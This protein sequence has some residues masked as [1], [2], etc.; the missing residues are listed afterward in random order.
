MNTPIYQNDFFTN[1]FHM[2]RPI[3]YA[4]A[5]LIFVFLSVVCSTVG[6]EDP[7][8]PLYSFVPVNYKH[9]TFDDIKSNPNEYAGKDVS[10]EGFLDR[11]L[12]A[13]IVLLVVSG[14]VSEAGTT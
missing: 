14:G 9:V 8:Q 3:F 1:T 12:A 5:G 2:K 11:A 7:I 6:A 10:V 13:Q 4:Q